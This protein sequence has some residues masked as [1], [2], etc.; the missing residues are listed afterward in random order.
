MPFSIKNI[1]LAVV[2]T[3]LLVLPPLYAL[4]TLGDHVSGQPVPVLSRYL[5]FLYAR[6]FRQAYRFISS[7]DRRLKRQDVYVRERGPFT[8]FTL[9]VAR[10]LAELI[11]IRA[12]AEQSDGTLNRIRVAMKLPDSGGVAPL[13]LDWDETRLNALSMPERK[14]ILASID[15]LARDN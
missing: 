5:N 3:V 11:E 4:V 7:E 12:V 10:R 9:D 13:L 8:G 6:D 14:T 15:N 2:A 1:L